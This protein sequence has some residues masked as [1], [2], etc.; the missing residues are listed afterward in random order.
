MNFGDKMQSTRDK[1]N[2][3]RMLAS[4][5]EIDPSEFIEIVVVK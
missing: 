1:T 2:K 4:L 3:K 5:D